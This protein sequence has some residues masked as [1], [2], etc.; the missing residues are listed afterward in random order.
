MRGRRALPF[1]AAASP[2]MAF[3]TNIVLTRD[4]AFSAADAGVG[5]TLPTPAGHF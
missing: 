2:L 5:R 1:V 3:R 4:S